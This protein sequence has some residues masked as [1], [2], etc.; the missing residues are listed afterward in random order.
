MSNIGAR[1]KIV[2]RVMNGT[3][4]KSYVLLD[5][6]NNRLAAIEKEI[7]EQYALN[8]QIYNCTAQI[9][10]NIINMK[11]I[12]CKLSQLP[13][14]NPD[15]TLADIKNKKEKSKDTIKPDIMIVGKIHDGR[16]IT[17]YVVVCTSEPDRT[18]KVKKSKVLALAKNNRIINAK[19]QY[20]CGELML[21]AKN[22][23]SL[24]NIASY[25][26]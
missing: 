22:G 8:K 3:I 12:D 25:V 11:G 2:G 23:F 5:M 18:L 1:Y 10:N 19:S 6:T 7:V 14:Y 24:N 15:C 9:Y 21:R 26:I 4:V 13:R 17:H 16:A 20:N